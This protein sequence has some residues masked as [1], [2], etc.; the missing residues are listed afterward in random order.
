VERAQPVEI[1]RVVFVQ[2]RT[3]H[4]GGWFD[5]SRGKP[6][7]QVKREKTGAWETVAALED[8]PA[9]TAS[10]RKGLLEGRRLEVRL[11]APV[12]AVAIRVIGAP[13][14]GDNPAQA[15]ASCAELEAFGK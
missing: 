1:A 10:D 2:G 13:A 12:R 15:F 9:A 5:A 4:D 14:S 8:Y 3:F 7:I 6:R 11:A